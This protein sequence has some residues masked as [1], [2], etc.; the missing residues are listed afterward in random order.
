MEELSLYIHIPFCARK[1][2]YCDFLSAPATSNVQEQYLNALINEIQ[3]RSKSY[4]ERRVHSIFIGGG[5]PSILPAEQIK[6]IMQ[7]IKLCFNILKDAEVSIEVNPGTVHDCGDFGIYKDSGI[8][9][10]SIGLQSADDKELKLLGRIHSFEQFEATWKTARQA[11][12]D[13]L[14]I[15]VMAA[16]PGQTVESYRNT[17]ETVCRLQPEH[18]SAYSLIIEEGTPFYE[19]YSNLIDDDEYEETDR[20]MYALTEEILLKHGYGRYEIS[21]YSLEGK[22]CRHNKVY[23]Q[24]LDYLGLGLGASSMINNVRYKNTDN[25]EMY[26]QAEGI[27]EYEDIQSLTVKEQMEEFMFLGLRLTEGVSVNKFKEYFGCSIDSVY[28][29]VLKKNEEDGLLVKNGDMVKL[30][31]KG[32]DLSNYVFAQFT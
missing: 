18:I 25:L 2:N 4:K 23:W 15:D 12:F 21:N 16:L 24:R 32:R 10:L 11:G 22:E 8:N 3:Q 7:E 6:K 26:I 20:Q 30:T 28:G 19:K 5:T 31:S 14:N 1:C 29:D 27:A 9:R 13:N 17:L